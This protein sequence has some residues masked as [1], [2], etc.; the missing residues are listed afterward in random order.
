[1]MVLCAGLLVGCDKK[2]EYEPV[3][4]PVEEPDEPNEPDKPVTPPTTDDII[5]FK[6]G[7]T[8]MI[9]GTNTWNG[10]AYGNGRYVVVGDNGY[11]TSSTDGITWET[12]KAITGANRWFSV[13]FGKGKFVAIDWYA[14]C[15]VMTSTDGINW[16]K[17]SNKL[18]HVNNRYYDAVRFCNGMFIAVGAAQ[19]STSA[20]GIT[21]TRTW[22]NSGMYIP[23]DI[24]YGNGKYV[25]GIGGANVLTS[26]DGIT[27]T[28]KQHQ[29]LLGNYYI[30]GIAFGNGIFV[31]VG[32]KGITARST[33]GGETWEIP[34]TFVSK[35][36]W[37]G[38]VF[39]NGKFIAVTT[40]GYVAT[41]TDGITWTTPEQIRDES[42]KVVTASLNGICAM[43]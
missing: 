35:K 3:K 4:P 11:V 9:I 28:M 37:R 15:N 41:S 32:N 1:M 6:I 38:I 12:P 8:D 36:N 20:N 7:D 2:E 5:N 17:Q 33:D 21:W 13:A 16:T 34:S 43:P 23:R 14:P 22:L 25:T 29:C 40:D 18:P 42:G 27:W 26:S 24:A 31:M 30:Y 39:S 10:I 19:I